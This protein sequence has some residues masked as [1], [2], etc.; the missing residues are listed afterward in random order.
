MLGRVFGHNLLFS[1]NC[2][3]GL[4][5]LCRLGFGLHDGDLLGRNDTLVKVQLDK[6]Q[7]ADIIKKFIYIG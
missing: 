5:L 1:F 7:P 2:F 3:W 4:L 6:L